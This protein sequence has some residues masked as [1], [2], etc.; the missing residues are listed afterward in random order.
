MILYFYRHAQTE[1]NLEH[2][3]IGR[4]DEPLCAAGIEAAVKAAR[5]A[6]ERIRTVYVTP[7]RR[8]LETAR[9]LFPSAGYISC[10]DLRE[11]DFGR[12]E[13]KNYLELANDSAYSIW[14]EGGCEGKCPGGESKAAFSDR[15]CTEFERI[16]GQLCSRH[17]TED[18]AFVLHGGTIMALFERYALPQKD[19]FDW[20][21]PNCGRLCLAFDPALWAAERK[22]PVSED[23]L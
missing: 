4:T 14:V 7:L 11:M 8:T 15:C 17:Q 16:A 5:S 22:L 23:V 9:I 3:Y 20:Q 12:F 19:Y 1:G 10:P 13:G 6:P 18:V 21:L 2:R